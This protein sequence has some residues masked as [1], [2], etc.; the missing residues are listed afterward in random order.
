MMAAAAIFRLLV[1]LDYVMTP[2]SRP[3]IQKLGTTLVPQTTSSPGW[4]YARRS[5]R[6]GAGR[7]GIA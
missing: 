4:G 6:D 7:G 1:L 3:V 5:D 2:S